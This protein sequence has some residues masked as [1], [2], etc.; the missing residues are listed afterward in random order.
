MEPVDTLVKSRRLGSLST[1]YKAGRLGLE[2]VDIHRRVSHVWVQR[3]SITCV[4]RQPRLWYSDL[5]MH[6]SHAALACS[7]LWHRLV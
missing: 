1:P 4:I 3:S 7:L 5:D 6:E 2:S